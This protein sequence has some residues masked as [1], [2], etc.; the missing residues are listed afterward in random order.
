MSVILPSSIST[1]TTSSWSSEPSNKRRLQLAFVISVFKLISSYVLGLSNFS[2][3]KAQRAKC[4]LG[5][6]FALCF[7]C[8]YQEPYI[9]LGNRTNDLFGVNSA[10]FAPSCVTPA[11]SSM[12]SPTCIKIRCAG[13]LALRAPSGL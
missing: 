8:H 7:C 13:K 2:Q 5:C 11:K 1:L 10:M 3:K 4:V 9:G 12:L 6:Y